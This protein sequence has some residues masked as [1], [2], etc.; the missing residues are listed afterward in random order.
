MGRHFA[1]IHENLHDIH[2]ARDPIKPGDDHHLDTTL[3]SDGST[4]IS[5]MVGEAQRRE[6]RGPVAKKQK[7]RHNGSLDTAHFDSDSEDEH[8]DLPAVLTEQTA[9]DRELLI[10]RKVMKKWWRLAGLSGHPNLADEQGEEFGVHWTKA[11]APQ[12]EGRI[13]IINSVP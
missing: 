3:Q 5:S 8:S 2:P 6:S 4:E 9:R 10:M 11:I 12:L 1:G 7:S 13:K